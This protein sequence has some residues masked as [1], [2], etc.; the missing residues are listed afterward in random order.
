[1]KASGR[2]LLTL[3]VVM[4]FVVACGKNVDSKN[5]KESTESLKAETTR[6]RE[7]QCGAFSFTDTVSY[8]K[9]GKMV[10]AIRRI[11]DDAKSYDVS[12][13]Y[14]SE[15][16]V[17]NYRV[18]QFDA[19]YPKGKEICSMNFSDGYLSEK[20][21]NAGLVL[22][23][24]FMPNNLIISQD[25]WAYKDVPDY[26]YEGVAGLDMDTTKVEEMKLR[27]TLK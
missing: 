25:D 12:I 13:H 16:N 27:K 14:D 26:R 20:A 4:L 7:G 5:N 10:E 6:N 15:G 3:V 18:V 24:N 2:L 8:Q 19:D 22:F 23:D 21:Y 9:D 17:S 11:D 1:M